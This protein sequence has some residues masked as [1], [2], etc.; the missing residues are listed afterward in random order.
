MPD[1]PKLALDVLQ[2]YLVAHFGFLPDGRI[3]GL[4][5]AMALIRAKFI[6]TPK[7]SLLLSLDPYQFE[8]LIQA[9]YEMMGYTTSLTQT[10]Y[11]RG[12]DVIAEKEHAGEREKSLI[13]CRRT[14][15]NVGVKEVRALLGVVSNEKAN[16]GVF[17][18]TSEFTPKAKEL[19]NE[20]PRLELIGNKDLQ[21][22]LN[23]YFG[24]KW[25]KDVDFII[26]RILSK[27]KK[28]SDA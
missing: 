7:S 28:K 5:D 6:E 27:S 17:V 8:V 15:R 10:T 13:Q 9:L 12:R 1:R 3:D 19:A 16:K 11:D 14:E 18:S 24:S 25:P 20:N 4:L 21:V 26:S 2:A 23:K 22:L